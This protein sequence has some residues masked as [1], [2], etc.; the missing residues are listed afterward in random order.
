MSKKKTTK[1][2]GLLYL[3]D[4]KN[5]EMVL[6]VKRE[7]ITTER[8][9]KINEQEMYSNNT[10]HHKTNFYH[11]GTDGLTFSCTLIFVNDLSYATTKGKMTTGKKIDKEANK[12]EINRYNKDMTNLK[13]L[14]KWYSNMHPFSIVFGKNINL[15]YLPKVSK[16][17]II[18]KLSMKQEADTFTEWDVTFRTY[19]PPRKIKQVK[20]DLV[21]RTSKSYKW[22][23]KCKKSYKKL[24]YKDTR[25][26]KKGSECAKLLN[27]ILIEMGYMKKAT[28]TVKYKDKKGNTKYKK[29]KYVP[30]VY[31]KAT[32]YGVKLFKKDWNRHKLKPKFKSYKKN[33][34][35][36]KLTL[37]GYKN[38]GN[39]AKLKAAKKKK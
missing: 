30:D 14:D 35:N 11:N 9:F 3:R 17:W 2:P 4:S 26:Q 13:L 23:A 22:K 15:K 19:N 39:Y 12:S 18:T 34:Y 38:I 16:K 6:K 33:Q 21:N 28:K 29:K 1:I 5:K 10:T 32:S 31:N 25:K 24:N 37:T 20:N 7:K 27:G 36:D 8:N